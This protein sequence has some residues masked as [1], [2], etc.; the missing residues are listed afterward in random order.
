MIAPRR[1]KTQNGAKRVAN[2]SRARRDHRRKFRNHCCNV[3]SSSL[4]PRLPPCCFIEA[5]QTLSQNKRMLQETNPKS[6]NNEILFAN[7]SGIKQG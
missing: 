1:G 2:S 6:R 3:I 7:I 4:P 5:Q